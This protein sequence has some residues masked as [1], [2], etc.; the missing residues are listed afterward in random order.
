MGTDSKSPTTRARPINGTAAFDGPDAFDQWS[1]AVSDA[2]VPLNAVPTDS[3]AKDFRGALHCA[4][5]G[6]AMQLS[7]VRGARVDVLRTTQTIR[8]SDPGFVKVGVQIRGSGI[9]RQGAHEAHLTPGDFAVYDTRT[10]YELHFAGDFTMFVV[11]LP[12]DAL[13]VSPG[14]LKA[15]SGRRISA[16]AGVG[17]LVSPFLVSL[18]HNLQQ[19]TLPAAPLLEDAVVELLSAACDETAPPIHER[20]GPTLLTSAKAFI[21]NNLSEL[22]LN[23]ALVAAHHHIST[24]YLQKLFE[25]DGLT[26][27]SWIR[28]RRLEKCRRELGDPKL[29]KETIRTISARY[30]FLDT[31][32]FS[33]LFKDTYGQSPRNYREIALGYSTKPTDVSGTSSKAETSP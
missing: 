31:A 33:R 15:V 18:R 16:H 9:L 25:S 24:R 20:S 1:R 22:N 19:G 21:E 8:K 28:T 2:F 17:T 7:E 10:P 6:S 32:H 4:P 12:H 23:T 13:R 5:L 27:T 3:S 29:S 14:R 30:A 26:V 11:M